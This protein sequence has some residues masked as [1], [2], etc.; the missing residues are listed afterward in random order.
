[1]LKITNYNISANVVID[2]TDIV[3][4]NASIYDGN[5]G[6]SFSKSINN[7]DLYFQNKETCDS[8]SA[9]FESKVQ[10]ILKKIEE[11]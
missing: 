4:L 2:D 11:E 10:D 9:A 1:M 3:Y 8:E 5:N 6:I 7:K